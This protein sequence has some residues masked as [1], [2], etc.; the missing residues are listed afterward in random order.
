MEQNKPLPVQVLMFAIFSPQAAMEGK[1]TPMT[2]GQRTPGLD[3]HAFG[4]R[5]LLEAIFGAAEEAILATTTRGIISACNTAAERLLGLKAAAALGLHISSIFPSDDTNGVQ[6]AIDRVA[7]GGKTEICE[8]WVKASDGRL[9]EC[10]LVR[11][12]IRDDE[13]DAAGVLHIAHDLTPRRASEKRIDDARKY[14]NDVLDHIP[15]PIFMKDREHR[16]IGGNLAFWDLLGGSPEKFIGKSDYEF[17]PQAE[18]DHFWAIDDRVFKGETITTEE[19]LTDHKGDRHVLSTKKAAFSN[20]MEGRFLVGVIHDITHLKNTE[21]HLRKYV[22]KL[23]QSNQDLDD[24]AAMASHDLKEPLRGLVYQAAFLKEDYAG[25]IDAAGVE[26]LDRMMALAERMDRLIDDL[27]YFSQLAHAEMAMTPTDMNEV[28]REIQAMMATQLA[29]CNG[30]IIVPAPL[31]ETVCDRQKVTEV[32]RNLIANGIRYNDKPER[33]VEIGFF[34]NRET[35]QGPRKDVYYVKD[36]GVGIDPAHHHDVFGLFRR[37]RRANDGS[38][39]ARGTGMGLTFVKKIIE[40][41]GGSIWL[42]SAP[43]EGT[44]FYFT[45]CA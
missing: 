15:D 2:R 6:A 19:F 32:F 18:A 41:G 40:R 28:V 3:T 35:P 45:L 42:D 25:K 7:S 31:P 9:V 39:G 23:E 37:I 21:D 36:N 34:E 13:G 4:D 30:R 17:F 1:S 38:N 29:D 12:L 5:R 27:L 24:A 10:R 11:A 16:W 44:T 14:L 20:E 33:N 8:T 22:R 43:G 26:R